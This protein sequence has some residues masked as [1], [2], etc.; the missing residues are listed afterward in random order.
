[1]NGIEQTR[2]IMVLERRSVVRIQTKIN[3][4]S[5]SSFLTLPYMYIKFT[6]RLCLFLQTTDS[7]LNQNTIS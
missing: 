7:I 2:R 5:Q 3:T 4:I 1:M 6:I